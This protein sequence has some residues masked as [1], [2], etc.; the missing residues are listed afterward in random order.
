MMFSSTRRVLAVLLLSCL[1]FV[2]K[3]QPVS[4][5]G[6]QLSKRESR[7]YKVFTSGK[8]VTIKST[9]EINHIMLWTT[10]GNRVVEQKEIN[11][12]SYTFSI[13]ISEKLYFLMVGLSDGKIYTEKIGLQ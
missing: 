11:A 13:P 4:N 6:D 3:G 10:S 8:Q 9:K 7:P 2:A 1:F 12:S 5:P